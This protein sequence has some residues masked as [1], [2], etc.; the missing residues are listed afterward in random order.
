MCHQV[1]K[2]IVPTRYSMSMQGGVAVQNGCMALQSVR[3]G[4]SVGPQ[5][6]ACRA[7]YA[8]LSYILQRGGRR[9]PRV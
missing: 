3:V 1:W 6:G 2:A 7:S 5:Y 4:R 9:R 8:R